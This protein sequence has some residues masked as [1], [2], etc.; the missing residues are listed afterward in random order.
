MVQPK[1][2]QY[3]ILL[4]PK[5]VKEIMEIMEIEEVKEIMEI[6]EEEVKD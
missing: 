1:I 6:I 3:Q 5:E 2:D 4:F